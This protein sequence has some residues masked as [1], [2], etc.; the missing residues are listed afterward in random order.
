MTVMGAL[1]YMLR[2]FDFDTAPVILGLIL[3]PD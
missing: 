2:K 3:A 1:G